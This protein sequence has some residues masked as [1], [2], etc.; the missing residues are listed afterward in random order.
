MSMND[1]HAPEKLRCPSC[2]ARNAAD[3]QWCGQ[4]LERFD[5]P[6]PPPPGPP[7]PPAPALDAPPQDHEAPPA[8]PRAV[9]PGVEH[10]SFRSTDEGIVWR[11]SSCETE[12]P[13]EEQGCVVCGTG[14]GDAFRPAPPSRRERDPATT[15]LVSLF[16]PGAGHAYLGMWPQAIA[17]GVISV[18][19][20]AMALF[21]AVGGNQV[22]MAILNALV[23]FGLWAVAAHDA[24]REANHESRLV[25]LHGRRFTYLVLGLLMLLMAS[26]FLTAF[27]NR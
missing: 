16:F 9:T 5:A 8:A 4:C 13:L 7:A 21:F 22:P 3:A 18:W 2:G 17:R 1:V 24:Y 20:V 27:S 15:A 26:M 11:C 10:G 25:L 14:F 23:A 12:N 19:V 6:A